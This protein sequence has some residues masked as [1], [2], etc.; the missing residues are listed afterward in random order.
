MIPLL[1]EQCTYFALRFSLNSLYAAFP[2]IF[3]WL[4]SLCYI[5]VS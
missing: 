3:N 2:S 5:K 4:G 1:L